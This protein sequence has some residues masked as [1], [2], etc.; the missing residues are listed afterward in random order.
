MSV[1]PDRPSVL[2]DDQ[3]HHIE[4][5]VRT[6]PAAAAL[7]VCFDP[8]LQLWPA[9]AF[10]LD[11][12]RRLG[13]DVVTVQRKH[14]HF[15][16]TLSRETL[17]AL[18]SPLLP[19]YR[20]VLMY[21]SSLG[22][23]AA[24]Y[25]GRDLDVMAI[26]VSPRVSVHPLYG[27]A[28]WQARGDWKHLR[29]DLA[30]PARCRAFIAYDPRETQDQRYLQ[31]E[32]LP[33]FPQAQVMLVPFS[34]H[35]STQMLQETGYL[36]PLLRA[37]LAG[38]PAPLLNRRAGRW[39]SSA[40]CTDVAERALRR[41]RVALGAHFAERA[42][43][44]RPRSVLTQRALARAR[45]LQQRWADA[46]TAL[47]A[48]QAL[49]PQDAMTAALLAQADAALHAL[50]SAAAP[51]DGPSA[52]DADPACREAEGSTQGTTQKPT[53]EQSPGPAHGP[54]SE[55]TM[56]T[57]ARVATAAAANDAATAAA[58]AAASQPSPGLWRSLGRWLR[59]RL[60][61]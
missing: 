53:L 28:H 61:R 8:L 10:G 45:L 13:A 26:A 11:F 35:P 40:W 58:A 39:A 15:Y 41:H 38:Q 27:T 22:A 59:R 4:W 37:A 54:T 36:G 31:T 44:L 20:R 18:L 51:Q 17:S 29:L 3:D 57:A 14:E 30:Q 16:Q 24:L 47:Q 55:A 9:P 33:Q 50:A 19:R 60:Q 2:L 23:Y 46:R 5:H 6:D 12:M 52:P 32:V 43:T 34:G 49:A 48:A 42:V 56:A 25:F 21:G 1:R 7:V